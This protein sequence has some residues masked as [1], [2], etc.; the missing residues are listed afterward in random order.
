MVLEVW[1]L[2]SEIWREISLLVLPTFDVLAKVMG[3]LNFNQVEYRV[4]LR[5]P[6]KNCHF[7]LLVLV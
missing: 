5:R 1:H 7:W 6:L 4:G 3:P 2:C